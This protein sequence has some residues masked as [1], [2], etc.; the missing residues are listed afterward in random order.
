MRIK[1]LR[2]SCPGN[3]VGFDSNI[4]TEN[5]MNNVDILR[6]YCDV[7]GNDDKFND[8]INEAREK[9]AEK[10]EKVAEA[11]EIFHD[12]VSGVAIAVGTVTFIAGEVVTG[13]AA[14]PILIASSAAAVVGG[15]NALIKTCTEFE[16]N[17]VVV[18]QCV[19][20]G[21]VSSPGNGK[22]AAIVGRLCD[23]CAVADCL[24]TAVIDGSDNILIG[25]YGKLCDMRNF[26]TL[27]A[28]G[29]PDY[30]YGL[31]NVVAYD[32]NLPAGK[33]DKFTNVTLASKD[34]M[35]DSSFFSS[36]GFDLG[37]EASWSIP[38]GETFPIPQ[39]SQMQD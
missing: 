4:M 32:P 14:T 39:R 33:T 28:A 24:N 21:K 30:F 11:K 15:A 37:D 2:M 25:N 34:K 19:N 16:T 23:G 38:A 26:I 5:Y 13:G 8:A 18:S 36:L 3:V 31:E 6:Q 9:R 17:A 27:V 10:L 35:A 29:K 20:S 1:E 7:E 12:V 22:G